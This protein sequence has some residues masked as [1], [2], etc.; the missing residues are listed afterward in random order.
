M[1]DRIF[2]PENRFW[3]FANKVADMVVLGFL[4]FVCCLP[5][6]TAGAAFSAF[7]RMMLELARDEEA[8]LFSGFFRGFREC[9]LTGTA[10]GVTH[11]AAAGFLVVDA[12][13]CLRMGSRMGA[14]L[15]GVFGA[16]LVLL[17]LSGIWVYPLIGG[18]GLHW[19]EAVVNGC[20]LAVRHLLAGLLG[21][22]MLVAAFVV[23]FYLPY[24]VLV[25]PVL[26]CYGVARIVDRALADPPQVE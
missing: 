19:R 7:W 5:L 12:F 1:L 4:C 18:W 15:A 3:T 2:D 14:F 8:H 9:F 16:L 24:G 25:L 17:C 20:L 10:A 21:L 26:A 13:L 23:S 22:G 11:F 6:V